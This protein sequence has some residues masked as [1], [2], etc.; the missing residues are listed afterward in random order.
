MRSLSVTGVGLLLGAL[1]LPTFAEAADIPLGTE[2]SP[3]VAAASREWTLTVGGYAMAQ[4]D[5]FGSADYEFAFKPII[6][7]TRADQLSRFSSF[8]DNPSFALFD[9]GIFEA[10]IVGK[11][12]WKRDSS[13]NRALKGLDDVDFAVEVGGYA[14]WYPVDWLRVRGEL[15]YGFGGFDGVVADLTADAIYHS[16]WWGGT[17]FSAGPRMTLTS[18]GFV[19]AYFGISD[20]ESIDAISH[21]NF[22]APYDPSGGIYSVGV[23]GQIQKDFGNGFRGSVFGEYRYLTGDAA[24]SPIVIQNGDRNQFQTGVSLSYTFFLGFQ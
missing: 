8:N 24:D 18:S 9:T 14:Q 3:A 22:Y 6:S 13:D 11:L 5:F 21:G 12:D 19:D 23:G 10:G 4:P 16:D 15:R 20:E 1:A 2:V 7:I 17:T